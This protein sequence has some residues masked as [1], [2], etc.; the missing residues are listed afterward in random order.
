MNV[1]LLVLKIVGILILAAL[2]IVCVVLLL[3]AGIRVSWQN[4]KA[5]IW[6][7]I[8]P[9]RRR[10]Y[11]PRKAK[12][13]PEG[14]KSKQEKTQESPTA[15]A[16]EAEA[17]A[18]K[19]NEQAE[20]PQ[21]GAGEQG[22]AHKEPPPDEVDRLYENMMGNPMKYV[23]L[24]S[25]WAKGPGKL[26]LAHLKVRRVKIVWTVTADDAAATAIAYG[27]LVSACNTAWAILE[28]L[29]DVRADELRLEPDFTGERAGERCFSC[30]ITARMY[31][32]VA[33]VILTVWRRTARWSASEKKKTAKTADTK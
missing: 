29:V 12:E 23:R 18:Q 33:S 27:A 25:H 13:N 17:S 16:E 7:S 14:E 3:P 1:V 6:L 15:K 20:P 30:Q 31:I 21:A 9:L 8:G 26:L 28:D 22:N 24:L 2:L 4:S 19:K 5:G 11:P 10:L 32:I